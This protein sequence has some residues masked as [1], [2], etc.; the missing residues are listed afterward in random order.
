MWRCCTG[1]VWVQSSEWNNTEYHH[2]V[3]VWDFVQSDRAA[4]WISLSLK[5]CI[6]KLFSFRIPLVDM[7]VI[8]GNKPCLLLL[9]ALYMAY[10]LA[11]V[12]ECS[13]LVFHWQVNFCVLKNQ[14]TFC[15]VATLICNTHFAELLWVS[16]VLLSEKQLATVMP[17]S[18]FSIYLVCKSPLCV[19]IPTEANVVLEK[20]VVLLPKAVVIEMLLFLFMCTVLF[21]DKKQQMF[22]LPLAGALL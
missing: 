4:A 21:E 8:M 20:I 18:A 7:Q 17:W 2:R 11:H 6:N 15:N 13:L 3:H 16:K 5:G 1:W 9:F 14:S 22:A 12:C 10:A 19:W